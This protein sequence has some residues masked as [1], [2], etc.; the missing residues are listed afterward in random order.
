MTNSQGEHLTAIGKGS[1]FPAVGC[2]EKLEFLF[3][4]KAG[5]KL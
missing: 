1:P 2:L 4:Y 3:E 5:E